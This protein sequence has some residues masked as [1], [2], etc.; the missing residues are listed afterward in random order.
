MALYN[1]PEGLMSSGDWVLLRISLTIRSAVS[2]YGLEAGGSSKFPDC[3][4]EMS[5]WML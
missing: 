4:V 5:V 2:L 1:S 3:I